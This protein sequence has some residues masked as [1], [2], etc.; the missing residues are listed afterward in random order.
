[1]QIDLIRAIEKDIPVVRNL[2]KFYIYDLS[3]VM[4]WDCPESGLFDG[5]D[6]LPQFWDEPV[7][8]PYRWPSGWTG[9]P[10][11]VRVND[12]MA[13]FCLVRQTGASSYDIGQ[14]F[15]LRRYARQGVGRY[16]AHRVFDMFPGDWE[17]AEMEG[18][19]PAQAFWRSIIGDYTDG[20]YQ[21]C[22]VNDVLYNIPLAAQKFRSGE[23]T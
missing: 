1:M 20:D 8:E 5:C 3:V 17:V 16:V 13:G 15:I 23:G 7:E 18:N 12:R 19:T 14:F 22:I 6:E 10:F 9:H 2:V 21:E 11:L 4:G